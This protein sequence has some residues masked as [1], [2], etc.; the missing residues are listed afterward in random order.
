MDLNKYYVEWLNEFPDITNDRMNSVSVLKFVTW[1]RNKYWNINLVD[2][3]SQNSGWLPLEINETMDIKF[4]DK[5]YTITR[6]DGT[7]K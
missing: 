6:N 5:N 7:E 3:I 1:F 4:D 2:I